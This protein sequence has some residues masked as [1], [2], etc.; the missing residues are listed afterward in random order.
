MPRRPS[1][2]SRVKGARSSPTPI[3]SPAL[4]IPTNTSTTTSPTE[5]EWDPEDAVNAL[6]IA[7]LTLDVPIANKPV[8]KPKSP[9]PFPFMDL[10]SELRLKIYDHHFAGIGP[11]V[12]LEPGNYFSIHKKLSILR[13]SR[14]VYREA[15]HA[16]YS[17]KTFRIF[18]IDGRY[19]R[20]KKGLLA[21][22]K[23]QSRAN[24][25]S[26]EL[27]VGPGW[28]KP[29]RSWVVDP[30]VGLADCVN[31]RRL[32]VYIEI[33]PSDNIF[34]GWRKNNGFYETFCQNLLDD[35]LKGLPNADRV[36][37][38]AHDSVKKAGD[39]TQGLLEI[40]IT[41][42]R[43]ICWG[44]KRGWTDEEELVPEEAALGTMMFAPKSPGWDVGHG[45]TAAT[46]IAQPVA[47]QA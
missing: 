17:T 39:M 30:L 23:P 25:T 33:D 40:A 35:V 42:N 11:V 28:G 16:F 19:G 24:M 18:P 45:G 38:D 13:V 41:N 14:Q 2:G 5:A 20:A 15:S 26:L 44:P 37:F 4:S 6:D 27:R 46:A 22:M 21:R 3:A 29:Y 31:V 12:D 43:T 34:N 10:P 32:C 1:K 7:N 8:A 36:Q 47:T 9:Q